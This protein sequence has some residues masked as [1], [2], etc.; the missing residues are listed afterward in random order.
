MPSFGIQTIIIAYYPPE[1]L[2]KS[3]STQGE[4]Q[5]KIS[6]SLASG[7]SSRIAAHYSSVE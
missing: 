4:V 1:V 7:K 3:Y 2:I 6:I 5:K